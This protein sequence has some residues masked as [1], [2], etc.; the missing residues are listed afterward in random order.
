[1]ACIVLQKEAGAA[2]KPGRP[3]ILCRP[4]RHRSYGVGEPAVAVHSSVVLVSVMPWPLQAFWPL[5]EV[6]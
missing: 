2:G 4:H 1:M 5:Q 3:S 6:S